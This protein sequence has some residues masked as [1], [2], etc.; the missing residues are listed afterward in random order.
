MNK[1]L[2]GGA[3]LLSVVLS[4]LLMPTYGTFLVLWASVLCL[5]PHG[6]RVAVLVVCMGI[7]CILPLIFLSVLRHFK[8]VTDLHVERRNQ[9]LV[10]Y[11]FAVVCYAAA[12]SY[13]YNCHSPQWFVMFMAGAALSVLLSALITLKWKISAH[14]TGM[15]GIVALIYQLH[16]QG[17]S[18]FEMYWLLCAAILLSGLLGSARL[19]LNRHS[20]LQV[21]AGFVLG[22]ACVTITMKFLG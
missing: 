4:P 1:M 18:A 21:I 17:L 12:A 7:T 5:L 15:G 11:L 19:I 14:M 9:R 8:L 3:H 13:L 2:A 20:T 6:T 10:P 22:Y 16:V